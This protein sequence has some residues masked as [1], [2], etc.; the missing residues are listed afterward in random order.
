[1]GPGWTDSIK[2]ELN[3]KG[4]LVNGTLTPRFAVVGVKCRWEL[5]LGA[6]MKGGEVLAVIEAEVMSVFPGRGDNPFV[7]GLPGGEEGR[8]GELA[9]L[10][11][12]K[13]APD[14]GSGMSLVG[15]VQ[16]DLTGGEGRGSREASGLQG[17]LGGS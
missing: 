16:G 11:L 7:I 8:S 2:S 13:V 10:G 9:L 17:G 12:P 5:L 4:I 3:Q 14:E 6:V 1:M 15:S